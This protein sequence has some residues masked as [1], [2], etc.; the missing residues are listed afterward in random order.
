MGATGEKAL[1]RLWFLSMTM[2]VLAAPRGAAASPPETSKVEAW[3]AANAERLLCAVKRPRH[4]PPPRDSSPWDPLETGHPVYGASPSEMIFWG[5]ALVNTSSAT[6]NDCAEKAAA[7]HITNLRIL[8][9]MSHERGLETIKV[10]PKRA[11]ETGVASC[12]EDVLIP[13]LIFSGPPWADVFGLDSDGRWLFCLDP[14]AED[15]TQ[16]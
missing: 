5:P 8:V 11:Y 4:E 6:A 13:R 12:V 14:A 2:L 16:E 15:P 7:A 1:A 9:V 3:F 10:S